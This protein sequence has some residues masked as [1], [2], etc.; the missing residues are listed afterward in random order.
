MSERPTIRLR[1]S[2]GDDETT[3][4]EIDVPVDVSRGWQIFLHAVNEATKPTA[5]ITFPE[6]MTAA[7]AEDW[8]RRFTR[9]HS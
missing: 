8:R 7:D 3:Q 2:L 9:S 1:V 4:A 5:V 6:P